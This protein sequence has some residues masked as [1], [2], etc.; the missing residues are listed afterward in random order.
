VQLPSWKFG[1]QALTAGKSQT[2]PA[3]RRATASTTAVLIL[4][5]VVSDAITIAVAFWIAYFLRFKTQLGVFYVPPESPLRFYSSL[6]FWLVPLVL[7][8]FACYRLYHPSFLFDS[9]DEYTR[10]VSASTLATLLIVLVSFSLD[11]AMVI[12]R[13]WI[14]ISWTV[15]ISCVALNRFLFRRVVYALRR[16][17][18]YGKRVILIGTTRSVGELADR[19][20]SS[21]E[22][23]IHIVRM[24]NTSTR[25]TE[26]ALTGLEKVIEDT[27]ADAVIIRSGAVTK[28]Q[29]RNL[30]GQLTGISTELQI[31]PDVHEIL[32]T[33]VRVREIRGLPLV[34]VNK[35]RITGFDLALKRALDYIVATSV[36]VL[37]APILASIALAIR[38]TS[39]GPVL[40]RRQVIGQ[41]KQRFDA[42]KFRTMYINSDELLARHPDLVKEL[43]ERGK[44]QHDPRITPVGAWLRRW[45][46]DE[47]P[48]LFNVIRGQMS[49][50]GPR[51]ITE[52]ELRHFGGWRENLYTVRPGLTGLWQVSGRSN[53][54]YEDRVR[55]D[56]HYIRTYSVWSD[57][58][59]LLRT[60][61]AVWS[62]R[63]AY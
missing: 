30:V 57:I 31:V 40:H 16:N 28:A 56:M 4:L 14:V 47:L 20:R 27:Q 8:V 51:M 46:L 33:G 39:P 48:Q 11:S 23:G 35:V 24:I 1:R 25:R 9:V 18:S 44:L 38:L 12:S 54:G 3:S 63:G 7:G 50:V 26:G 37:L 49:L 15:V 19:I 17:G 62:G 29:L 2:W 53:L 22:S 5:L 41:Q 6:V 13:G 61:P 42:L 21:P 52:A 58:E 59:I 55:L 45:S 43:A 60:I 36:L 34:T 10:I 32:T